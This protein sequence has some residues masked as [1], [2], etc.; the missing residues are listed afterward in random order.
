MMRERA[1]TCPRQ[2]PEK[3]RQGAPEGRHSTAPG[4]AMM[5]VHP[6][7]GAPAITRACIACGPRPGTG[8]ERP[9]DDL[10]MPA[11]MAG[12]KQNDPLP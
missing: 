2:P 1:S 10:S 5:H 11:R 7:A 12:P 4:R 8:G 3:P 6:A 9:R